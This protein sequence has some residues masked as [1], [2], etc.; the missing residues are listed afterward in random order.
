[1]PV[2]VAAMNWDQMSTVR[3]EKAEKKASQLAKSIHKRIGHVKSG[4]KGSFMFFIMKQMHKEMD[5]NPLEV[6]YWKEQGWI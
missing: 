1:M 6:S 2:T 4:L 5:Y 3:K